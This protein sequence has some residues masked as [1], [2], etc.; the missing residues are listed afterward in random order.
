MS[1]GVLAIRLRTLGDV[2]LVTPAL[3]ALARGF[4]GAPMDVLTEAPYVEL[5]A[6]LPGVREVMVPPRG[7]LAVP[8]FLARLRA[9]RYRLAVDFFGNPR[10]ALLARFS[11]A[12]NVAGYEVRGRSGAYRLRVPRT[13][14][15]AD[16][17]R[18]SAAATHV[19]L[20]CAAGGV[21]D[22]LEPRL[23]L[24]AAALAEA[25]GLIERAGVRDASRAVGL[26][27]SA[28]WP[29]KGWPLSHSAALARRLMEAGRE[30]L[31]LGGPGEA[32]ALEVV[33]RLAPGA[34]VLPPCRVAALA[35]V[36]S[37]LGGVAGTDSGPRHLAAALGVP[38]VAWFGPTH[39]ENWQP[40]GERHA[41]WFTDVPCR[42][43][44]RT[45]CPHWVCMTRLAPPHAARLVLHHLERHGR[46][47]GLGAA[48]GA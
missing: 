19:R 12:A 36:I 37:R 39:P 6:A 23:A 43:C 16:G 27:A 29:T 5:L 31:L 30:V 1:G 32:R 47:A 11:G 17:R 8:A 28:T 25:P 14:R 48:A 33:T 18:E 21:A 35:A 4:P 24:P 3:R 46:P 44:D 42:G 38:S 9:R 34:R 22:G 15:L 10:S 2:V 7:A 20:A 40:P 41:Y 13:L 45:S 26:V